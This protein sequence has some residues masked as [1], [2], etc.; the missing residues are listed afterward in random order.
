M[1]DIEMPLEEGVEAEIGSEEIGETEVEAV[2]EDSFEEPSYDFLDIDDEIGGKH[3]KVKV[4]G[5]ELIVPLNEALQGFSRT[6]DY[7]R[8]TQEAADMRRQADEALRLQQAFQANPGLTVQVLASQAGVSVEDFLGMSP[9]QQQAAIDD[10]DGLDEY[11]DPLERQLAEER[12]ARLALEQKFESREADERLSHAVGGL[13]QQFGATDDQARA[14]VYQAMQMNLG[15]DSFPMIYQAM[16]YQAQQQATA[17]HTATQ[18]ADTQQ[19]RQAA[20]AASQVVSSGTGVPGTTTQQ[21]AATFN[22][23]R[24]AAAAAID[25]VESRAAR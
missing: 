22:S 16:A 11:A 24:E 2:S 14:V 12:Q 8:K 6:Q 21:P 20:R 10:S 18:E 13:K 7:T 25:E 4:D 23:I 19:R 3:V 1:S 9:R 17:Q 15:I 5:E